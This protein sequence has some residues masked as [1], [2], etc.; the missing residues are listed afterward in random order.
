MA[1]IFISFITSVCMPPS[2]RTNLKA[3]PF[4]FINSCRTGSIFTQGGHHLAPKSTSTYRV[5][6]YHGTVFF[7]FKL[8][9]IAYTF[10]R[11]IVSFP[12]IDAAFQVYYG[13]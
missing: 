8:F 5:G 13:L 12:G 3:D 6:G 1:S 7:Y 2:I 11:V 9:F 4:S 10:Q